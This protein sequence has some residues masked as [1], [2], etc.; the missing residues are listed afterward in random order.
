MKAIPVVSVGAVAASVTC[1]AG[2]LS[3]GTTGARAQHAPLVPMLARPD[4][5]AGAP[6]TDTAW[7]TPPSAQ[8]A[9]APMLRAGSRGQ[10]LGMAA[11]SNPVVASAPAAQSDAAAP[12]DRAS[13]GATAI[14][15][16]QTPPVAPSS[17]QGR[18]VTARPASRGDAAAWVAPPLP[19]DRGARRA[20]QPSPTAPR[21]DAISHR[22]GAPSS[23]RSAKPPAD[24]ARITLDLDH[25]DASEAIRAFAEFTGLN[26]V[27]SEQVRGSVTL[28]LNAVPWRQAFAT[29]LDTNGLAMRTEGS[30]IWVAPAAEIAQRDKLQLE[31]QAKM[32]A[33]EPLVTRTFALRYQRADDVRKLL[34]G[35][36]GQRM[37]SKRGAVTADA[38]TDHLF[39]SDTPAQLA[40]IAAMI[41]AIDVPPRQVLIESR[42]IEADAS[43]DRNLGA[44]LALLGGATGNGDSIHGLHGDDQGNLYDLGAGG[45]N[46]YQPASLGVTLFSAGDSRELMLQLSAL[47]AE[48]HGRTVSSPRVVTADRVRALV[49]QGTELP[50]QSMVDT[51]VPSVEFRRAT[52]K[53]EVIP[54]ITPDHHVMLDVDVTKDSVGQATTAGPAIDTKHVQTQ[55]EV[56]NGGTVAIGGI[57]IDE[58]RND[59]DGVPWFDH[60][61]VLG[62]LFR[63]RA[64]SN[65]KNE[66]MIFIT[67]TEVD[68]TVL[69]LASASRGAA[70]AADARIPPSSASPFRMPA[71]ALPPVPELP[72]HALSVRDWSDEIRS[73]PH[74]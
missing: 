53:L 23:A 50:Y 41:A 32:A 21:A 29:L 64:V 13:A 35:S 67:P 74:P 12:L 59:T 30:V 9:T 5:S 25:V 63:N 22:T 34:A 16:S 36:G 44:R 51:G 61:P 26:I 73:V 68:G 1:A 46:G 52:L 62:W 17:T 11:M 8:S 2:L 48:G 57:Y 39:V 7:P 6:G 20:S 31:T 49:E 54:H 60:L 4:A 58:G 40:Q 56:E 24:D 14:A 43:F 71:P 3:V 65:S 66:L 10:R 18:A 28:S 42:I 15:E 27:A 55:V 72:D 19:R 33:L 69:K 38:R 70:P 37:L 45:L 47:E